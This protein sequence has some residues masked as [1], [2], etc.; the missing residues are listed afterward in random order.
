MIV[1]SGEKIMRVITS[2]L[3]RITV[4]AGL[5]VFIAYFFGF[6]KIVSNIRS[7][8]P[9]YLVVAFIVF[10]LSG[11][12][13]ALQWGILLRFHGIRSG[14]SGIVACYF[15]GLFFNYI[16]PGFVGGD[17]VRVYKASQIS[18]KTTKAFSST[19]ADRVIGLLM[20]VLLSIGAF[21]L[22]PGGPAAGAFPLALVMFI[23]LSGL[24]GVIALRPVGVYINRIFGRFLPK[25]FREKIAAVY[26]EMHELTR[27][28]ATLAAVIVTSFF[29]Q[30]TRIMV[31]FLCGKAV[32]IELGFFYFAMFVPII[33]I[34]ASIPI[35]VGGVGVRE[36][37]AISLFH[38]VGVGSPYVVAYSLLAWITGFIV[39]IP[40]GIVFVLVGG[41]RNETLK[42]K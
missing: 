9:L 11:V 15:T 38:T 22:I 28:P 14:F 16:L 30:L 25:S 34:V 8:Q 36:T 4:S 29:I 42:R 37:M 32:G 39:S 26:G 6:G 23:A 7:A 5:L 10:I 2:R 18:G 13:G 33:E 3:F 27:S 12:L 19:L 35:S 24:I 31:H 1:F 21:M 41:K 17:V 20:L 40:F